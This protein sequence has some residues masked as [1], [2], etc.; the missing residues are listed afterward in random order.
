MTLG[1][2][3]NQ[4]EARQPVRLFVCFPFF[5]IVSNTRKYQQA[6]QFSS[7]QFSSAQTHDRLGRRGDTRDNSAEILI[8]SFQQ[9][10]IAGSFDMGKDIR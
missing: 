3:G 4:I 2:L 10:A 6:S 5:L 9:E 8:Q 1:C 7:V